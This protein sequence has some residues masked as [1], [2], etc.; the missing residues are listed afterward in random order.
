MFEVV[1]HAGAISELRTVLLPLAARSWDSRG[2]GGSAEVKRN[3]NESSER[4][5]APVDIVRKT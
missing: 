4:A 1:A 2:V 5:I 3:D